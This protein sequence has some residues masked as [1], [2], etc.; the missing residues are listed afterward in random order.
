MLQ[1]PFMG[2]FISR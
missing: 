2:S 1:R